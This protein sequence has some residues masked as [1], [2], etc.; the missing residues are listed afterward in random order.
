MPKAAIST[1]VVEEYGVVEQVHHPLAKLKGLPGIMPGELVV[2]ENQVYGQVMAFDADYVEVMVFGANAVEVGSSVTRTE[3]VVA[4]PVSDGVL[5][6]MLDPL[7]GSLLGKKPPASDTF[8]PL[9]MPPVK[10][11]QRRRITQRLHTGVALAD[12]L[13]PIGK[14]QRELIVGD[15]K[16]GKSAFVMTAAITQ[17]HENTII[18]YASIGKKSVEIKH[19]YDTFSQAGILDRVVMI[20]SSASDPVSSIVLTPYSAMSIAEF[21][22]DQGKDV[23]VILDDLSQHAKFYRELSLLARQFPGRDSYP[24]NIFSIHAQLLERAGCFQNPVKP[25]SAV[26]ITCFPLAETTDSDLTEYIVSNLISITDG[27]LLFDNT[28]FQQGQRPAIQTSLSVTRVGKQTQSALERE[29]SRQ[30][31]AFM[32][33]YEKIKEL[34][35]F[36]NELSEASQEV[37]LQGNLMINFFAQPAKNSLPMK[38]Q[39][40]LVAIIWLGWFK[41]TDRA[42]MYQLIN[43]LHSAY[44]DSQEI[45]ARIDQIVQVE[46]FD[47]LLKN[48]NQERAFISTICKI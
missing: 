12:M 36:G 21:F 40:I 35:H 6:S 42:S 25:D 4:F 5:G 2:F 23:L 24:G 11:S 9:E 28:L 27:H 31:S 3:Q 1:P 29:V 38:L 8:R 15:R 14:G 20:A 43:N 32:S 41:K 18:V 47:D 13:L 34:T 39:H 16:T 37:I 22:R 46:T 19:M 26:S 33:K 17:A 7:G 45:R 30:V 48:V 10:L 44:S